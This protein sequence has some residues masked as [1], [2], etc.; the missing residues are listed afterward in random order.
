M[1][2]SALLLEAYNPVDSSIKGVSG[3][4]MYTMELV[5]G[6]SKRFKWQTSM[7][8]ESFMSSCREVHTL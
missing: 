3:R 5:V 6:S 1:V 4:K 2:Q 7:V 8:L